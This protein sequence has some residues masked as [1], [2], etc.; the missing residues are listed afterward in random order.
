V[1]QIRP[2]RQIVMFSATWPEEVETLA[3]SFFSDISDVMKVRI[4][5]D[6]TSANKNVE[7]IV[8]VVEGKRQ[9][10]Q[11]LEQILT[12]IY[13]QQ[14][15]SIVFIATKKMCDEVCWELKKKGFRAKAIHGNKD[16]WK[17]D[18][19][20]ADFKAGFCNHLIATDVASRGIHVDDITHVI[21]Y[22]YPN[23]AEDYVH[24]IGRTGRAGTHGKAITFFTWD[25]AKKSHALIKVLE[26]SGQKV[27]RDL[28]EIADATPQ[29]NGRKSWIS[30][31][32][33]DWKKEE[34]EGRYHRLDGRLP[35][36]VTLPPSTPLSF[37]CVTWPDRQVSRAP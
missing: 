25:D 36:Q 4:G 11:R 14:G 28:Q 35:G 33:T 37:G 17:R 24:R 12:G 18:K 7:Q 9:K 16:Q 29:W 8:E 19:V 6:Q 22:D 26:E 30:G 20:L 3:N 21:N 34:T 23:N 32:Y 15:K 10:D 2:D 27:P 5:N 31:G 13:E 1:G